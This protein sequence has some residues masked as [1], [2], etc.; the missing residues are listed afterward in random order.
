MEATALDIFHGEEAGRP[1]TLR[2]I[3]RSE[4]LEAAICMHAVAEGTE[5][6]VA[7]GVGGWVVGQRYG[8]IDI[9]VGMRGAE[10]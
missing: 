4:R 9:V 2:H 1:L 5:A 6:L 3:V 7:P 8:F 10:T